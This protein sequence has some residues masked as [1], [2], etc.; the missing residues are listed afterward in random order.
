MGVIMSILSIV[1]FILKFICLILALIIALILIAIFCNI[2]FRLLVNNKNENDIILKISYLFGIIS[3]VFDNNN[4]ILTLKI[5]GVSIE[6]IKY[7]FK[8]GKNK[9]STKNKKVRENKKSKKKN[10]ENFEENKNDFKLQD[11]HKSEQLPK[12]LYNIEDDK[13]NDENKSSYKNTSEDSSEN[14]REKTEVINV[15]VIFEKIKSVLDYPNKKVIIDAIKNLLKG[16]INS[17]KVKYI[18]LDLEYGTGDP[19]QTGCACG[20][21]SSLRPFLKIKNSK[22]ISVHPNFEELIF[23]IDL[24]IKGKTSIFKLTLPIIKFLLTK[25]IKNIIFK[26]G[27]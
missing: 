2:K 18:S 10:T 7:I 1:L 12:E 25:P 3:F 26:K 20:I 19:Y 16:L 21:I 14:I 6:K 11:E 17:I 22:K 9:K 4:D 8:F 24:N 13:D 27:E 23:D 5:F 15:K